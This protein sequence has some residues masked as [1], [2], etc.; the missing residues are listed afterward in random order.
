MPIG[1]TGNVSS[2]ERI[3]QFWKGAA[4]HAAR[5][6]SAPQSNRPG[7]LPSRPSMVPKIAY[8][9]IDIYMQE[10]GWGGSGSG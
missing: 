8:I 6:R 10:E 5:S 1:P 3:S 2:T 9:Y 4:S 7:G